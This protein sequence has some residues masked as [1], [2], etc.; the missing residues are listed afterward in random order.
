MTLRD[1]ILFA[2]SLAA[3]ALA[4]EFF[5]RNLVRSLPKNIL[6]LPSIIFVWVYFILVPAMNIGFDTYVDERVFISSPVDAMTFL[7]IV[8]AVLLCIAALGTRLLRLPYAAAHPPARSIPSGMLAA[9][10]ML[11]FVSVAYGIY[12]I[13]LSA[14]VL[15]DVNGQLQF[16]GSIYQ[17][18]IIESGPLA[19]CWLVTLYFLSRGRR[20]EPFEALAI[21]AVQI[22]LI[23]ALSSSRGSRVAIISQLLICAQIYN[24]YVFRFRLRHYLVGG[25]AL[26]AFLQVYAY[27]KYGG[28][29]VLNDYVSGRS[30]SATV[31]RYNNPVT[32]V[33][34]DIGRADIQAPLIT[35]YM[36]GAFTPNYFGETYLSGMSLLLPK[37]LRPDFLRPKIQIGA[38]AQLDRGG[39]AQDYT[40]VVLMDG[41]FVSS[42]IYG[43]LGEALLNFG[44]IGP[45]FAFLLFGILS[46]AALLRATNFQT[47]DRLLTTPFFAALPIYMLF[48][49]FDNLIVQTITVWTVPALVLTF[50]RKSAKRL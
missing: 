12:T 46:R 13:Y 24:F 20:P 36:A 4:V 14:S 26:A 22:F 49:D 6:I 48:Y 28:I 2:I 9:L 10:T 30:S 38:D 21:G 19:F 27:Y 3:C 1:V 16:S 25:I 45:P 18:L 40:G 33:V 39:L 50:F 23:L 17:Y 42:R 31:E 5:V 15:K 32:F 29:N 37:D 11:V 43:L 41:N 34:G 7:N 47:W 44:W 35:R 8:N